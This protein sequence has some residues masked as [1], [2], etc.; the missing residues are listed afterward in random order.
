MKVLAFSGGK[1][2]MACLHLLAG[3]LDCAIY[4]NTGKAYPETSRMVEYASGIV[5]I[6]T[7]HAN[8]DEQNKRE[9][10]P[11]DV[12]PVNW[13]RIG[14]M[15]TGRKE[16]LIQNYLSCCWENIGIPLLAKAKEIGADEIVYGQ[17]NSE[18]HKSTSRNGDTVDGITR[19]HPIE[20]WTDDQVMEYLATKMEIP[21][22]YSI[23]HSSLDCYDCTAYRKNSH[24]RV[25]F[26]RKSYP[27]MYQEYSRRI[28]LLN[29]ALLE[30][31]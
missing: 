3:S 7:V 4:V 5:P 29:K 22:H 30:S 28:D 12:V 27:E 31:I 9:G 11:A 8:Q 20:N 16:V 26:M 25:E 1:D 19:L 14:Q 23:K 2:S 10:L 18:S 15:V 21:E 13:T 17:R 6:I 24:D